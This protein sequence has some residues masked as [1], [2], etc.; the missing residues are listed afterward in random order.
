M[1]PAPESGDTGT[2]LDLLID[3]VTDLPTVPLLLERM[4]AQ[5][6]EHGFLSVLSINILQNSGVERVTGWKAFDSIVRDVGRFLSSIKTVHLRREDFVS[7]VMISGNA[8]SC[9]DLTWMKWI[10]TPS[11]S[12]VNCGSAFS[13]A[14]ALRQS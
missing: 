10:S 4:R 2:D 11:I 8:F 1:Q 9:R 6:V 3:Q 12:V 14:S 5:L 13:F 7:E